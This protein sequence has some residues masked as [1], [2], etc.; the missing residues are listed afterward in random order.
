[1]SFFNPGKLHVKFMGIAG[2]DQPAHPRKYTL[3]HSD[4]TGDLFLSIGTEY[5]QAAISG[6]YTCLMRDEVLAEYLIKEGQP[7]LW[8][9]C[10]VSGGLVL[11]P[12]GWRYGIFRHHL[13]GVLQAFRHGDDHFFKTHTAYSRAPVYVK[14][15]STKP[16][17]SVVELWGKI[18]DYEL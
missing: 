3:T 8:V 1:M 7:E 5:D 13:L 10:H 2:P 16:R 12:A 4:R 9:Y 11:G 17:Y 18:K 14:F 6:W 15:N